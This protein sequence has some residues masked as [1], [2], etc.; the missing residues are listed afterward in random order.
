MYAI[1]Q[2]NCV[3]RGNDLQLHLRLTEQE[4]QFD[5]LSAGVVFSVYYFVGTNSLL[6]YSG[7][8]KRGV[9]S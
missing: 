7:K 4:N 1:F 8:M 9:Q 2:V 6:Q 5:V 3:N